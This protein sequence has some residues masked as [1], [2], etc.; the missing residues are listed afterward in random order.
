MKP[1]SLQLYTL[2]E[3]AAKDFVGVLKTVAEIG[4]VGVE[5]AGLHGFDPKEI[6]KIV[7]DLGLKVS[8]AHGPLPTAENIQQVVD[9]E[10][11]LGN[12]RIISGFGP[13]DMST[14]ED[15]A[16][17]VEK[18]NTAA[19]LLKPHGM[20]FGFHNHWWEFFP[21]DGQY[22]YD[23]LMGETKDVFSELDVY[24]TAYGKAD[25]VA[26]INK[27]KSRLPLLHIKDGPLEEGKPHMAVGAGKLDM[28]AI[29]SAADPNV[30]EWLIVELD[31]CAT[32]MMEAVKQSYTYL[33]SNGLASGN[34]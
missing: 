3:E 23:V 25:P 18:F 12:T 2:R 33:V 19:E 17:V 11:I 31:E 26:V 15:R 6:K 4:Y 14:P 34:K 5:F 9:V 24:W 16:K 20:T 1:I 13:N 10:S 27:Y 32:D 30:L 8:S 21:A 7:D 28:P 29:I 22:I